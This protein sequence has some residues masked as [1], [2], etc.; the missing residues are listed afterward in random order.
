MQQAF[1]HISRIL[2]GL[3]TTACFDTLSILPAAAQSCSDDEYY[4]PYAEREERRP[5]LTS[6]TTLFYRAVQGAEDLYGRYTDFALPPV[7]LRRRGLDYTSE[8]NT[9]SGIGLSFSK[10]KEREYSE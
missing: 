4:Y 6:D 3:L 8:R 7:A 2:L 10:K 9:L 5:L 1:R